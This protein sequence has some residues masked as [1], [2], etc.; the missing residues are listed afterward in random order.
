MHG[1]RIAVIDSYIFQT[2]TNADRLSSSLL[3]GMVQEPFKG[4]QQ[5][6]EAASENVMLAARIRQS[7]SC[8][9]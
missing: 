1:K 3:V 4:R 8:A 9:V 6:L 2:F 7:K 5:L